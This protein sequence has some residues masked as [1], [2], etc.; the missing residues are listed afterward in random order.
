MFFY[1]LVVYILK[2][3]HPSPLN[4]FYIG[5]FAYLYYYSVILAKMNSYNRTPKIMVF[6]PSWA[7]FQD[8]SKYIAFMESQG[9]HKAGIAKV[10]K[11]I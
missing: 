5:L 6:R 10:C 11:I 9:A 2:H 3:F 7:E 8:F 1:P 4:Y